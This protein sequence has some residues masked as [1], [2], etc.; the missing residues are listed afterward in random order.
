MLTEKQG[1]IFHSI[2]AAPVHFPPQEWDFVLNLFAPY[3]LEHSFCR[4]EGFVLNK[5]LRACVYACVCYSN[6]LGRG[7]PLVDPLRPTWPH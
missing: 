5:I 3:V 4:F 7:V 2:L 1:Q 6:S